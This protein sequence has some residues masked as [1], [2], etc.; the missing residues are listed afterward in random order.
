MSATIEEQ[1]AP[2]F[3]IDH[4]DEYARYFLSHPHEI[5]FHL[6]LLA[7]R[8][9]LVT[10]YIDD[11][12]QFFLT[13]LVAVNEQNGTIFLDPASVESLNAETQKARQLTL[14]ANID[15]VKVQFRLSGLHESQFDGRRVLAADM[16]GTLLRLQ[17]REFFRLEPP[18]SSPIGCQILVVTDGAAKTIEPRV[19]DISGGGISLAAP[20]N[21]AGACQPGTLFNDCRLDLPGEGV[22]LVHLRVRKMVEISPST[23]A[24]NLRLGC[25]FVNLPGSRL[26]MIE[27]YITRIERERKA[28]ESGLAD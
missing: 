20:T 12:K 9:P 14:V 15:R 3:E 5:S 13:A 18:L 11:G 1:P 26:A 7:K 4:P 27:R 24:H 19:A 16:P 17:R 28:R 21:L 23:G 2:D 6:N 8:N 22:L 10:A 25:E